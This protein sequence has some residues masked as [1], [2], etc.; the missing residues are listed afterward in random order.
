[1]Q[2]GQ[3]FT[4]KKQKKQ[5]STQRLSLNAGSYF[6]GCVLT[7]ELTTHLTDEFAT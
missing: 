5:K 4:Q 3:R 1:M 6:D 2:L 7:P